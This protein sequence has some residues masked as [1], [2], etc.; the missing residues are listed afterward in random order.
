MV[1]FFDLWQLCST[2]L[3]V[4]DSLCVSLYLF[5]CL[6]KP[7]TN[8]F[9]QLNLTSSCNMQMTGE[10]HA[11]YK[12]LLTLYFTFVLIDIDMSTNHM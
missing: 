5:S 6:M 1:F 9:K 4:W 12:Q 3:A 2:L 7:A 11:P 10:Y 8:M